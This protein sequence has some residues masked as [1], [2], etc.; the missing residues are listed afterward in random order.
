MKQLKIVCEKAATETAD[1]LICE[2]E[3]AYQTAHGVSYETLKEKVLE[4]ARTVK[5]K[6]VGFLVD[7]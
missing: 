2:D 1:E 3:S 4:S 6:L 7:E 5:H